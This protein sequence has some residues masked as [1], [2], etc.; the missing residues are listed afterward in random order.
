MSIPFSHCQYSVRPD[1]T[2]AGVWQGRRKFDLFAERDEG[3]HGRQRKLVSSI[4][5][6]SSLKELEKWVDDAIEVFMRRME[7]QGS[8]TVDLGK[9]LQIFAFGMLL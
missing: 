1:L 5:A 4:Y 7:D 9:W 3:V 6:M 2:N 8:R